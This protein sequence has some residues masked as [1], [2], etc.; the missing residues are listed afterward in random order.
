[1][2][3]AG[4]V[5]FWAGIENRDLRF[6]KRELRMKNRVWLPDCRQI[7]LKPCQRHIKTASVIIINY[8]LIAFLLESLGIAGGS[9]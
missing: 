9:C 1:M 2:A 3:A 5:G 7:E 4:L 8:A 6:E